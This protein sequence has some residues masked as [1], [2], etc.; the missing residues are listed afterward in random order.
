[1]CNA[2]ACFIQMPPDCVHI[3]FQAV[4]GQIKGGAY[5]HSMTLDIQHLSGEAD[6]AL[7]AIRV[8]PHNVFDA[9]DSRPGEPA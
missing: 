5:R 3:Y 4:T 1:M 9:P 8:R 6:H 2:Y 7:A